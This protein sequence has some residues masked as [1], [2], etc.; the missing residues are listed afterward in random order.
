MGREV[1]RGSTQFQQQPSAAL[2]VVGNGRLRD[3][4][5]GT[6]LS[7][8]LGS[9]SRVV[10]PE[11]RRVGGLPVRDPHPLCVRGIAGTRPVLRLWILESQ[12]TRAGFC[13]WAV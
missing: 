8:F 1:S 10:F 11:I 2:S 6:V 9:G 5:F 13:E 4:L 3:P 7:P 12:H